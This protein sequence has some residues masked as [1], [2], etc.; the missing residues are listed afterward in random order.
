M[1]AYGAVAL[2]SH[3][4]KNHERYHRV[5]CLVHWIPALMIS[6][7]DS[8]CYV[9]RLDCSRTNTI[10]IDPL[11][12]LAYLPTGIAFALMAHDIWQSRDK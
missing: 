9:L 11:V 2:A 1:G 12:V 10:M 3:S 8:P 7:Y 5:H 4:V 6:R